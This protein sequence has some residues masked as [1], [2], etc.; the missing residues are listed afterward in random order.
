[1]LSFEEKKQLMNR[2]PSIELS[3]EPILHTKVY[4]NVYMVLPKGQKMIAWFTYWKNKNICFFMKVNEKGQFVNS[5]NDIQVF[6]VSFSNEVALGTILYGTFFDFKGRKHFSCEN[7]LYYKGKCLEHNNFETKIKHIGH[8]FSNNDIKQ[9]FYTKRCVVFGLPIIKRN[10]TQAN[11]CVNTLPYGAYGI[12][13]FQTNNHHPQNKKESLGIFLIKNQR[14]N[15]E[16]FFK[17]KA[18]LHSDIYNLY[19]YNSNHQD[20]P[21][22]TA[23]ISTYKNSVMM[24]SLFRNIKENLNL[25]LLEESDDEEEFQ[26]ISENK[27]VNLDK[28]YSMKCIFNKRV[29]KWEPVSI[30]KEPHVK[31]ITYK[32]AKM[33]DSC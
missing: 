26:N 16:G 32:E 18:T 24:N 12:Q 21:Y 6:P 10:Y 2:F 28:T 13:V 9:K 17:V 15:L 22:S 33:I 4:G 14:L 25:D 1:M 20:T 11:E 19:C 29:K 5:L 27:F 3:Y 8:L 30:F 7:I 23:H 31:L